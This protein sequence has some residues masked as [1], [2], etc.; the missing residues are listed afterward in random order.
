MANVEISFAP[1]SDHIHQIMHWMKH[2]D[3]KLSD[4]LIDNWNYISQGFSE[5]RMAVAFLGIVAVGFAVWKP[6]DE[7]IYT[8]EYLQ[9]KSDVRKKGIGRNL[10][11][12]VEEM[13]VSNGG[14]VMIGNS[15]SDNSSAFWLEMGN[16][17]LPQVI[18]G[19]KTTLRDES[20]MYKILVD[21]L[22]P[23]K[24]SSGSDTLELWAHDD[25]KIEVGQ[26]ADYVW[27]LEFEPETRKL[28]K[29]IIVAADGEWRIKWRINGVKHKNTIVKKFTPNE[30]YGSFLIVRN[31]PL[32]N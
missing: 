26:P 17:R 6:H 28:A 15:I 8:I 2:D 10:V 32:I 11:T 25:Y 21:T 27:S 14:L 4:G 24:F 20:F 1:T 18:I 19:R 29:P 22:D 16:M 3:R 31:L 7:G 13:L 5:N 9:I 12:R 30:S 23:N